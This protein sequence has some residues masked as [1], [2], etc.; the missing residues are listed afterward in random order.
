MTD[1][2]APFIAMAQRIERNASSDFAGAVVIVP[3]SD[4]N[5]AAG[6]TIE[7]LFLDRAPN[8]AIFWSTLKTAI[9]IVL[10]ELQEKERQRAQ[11]WGIR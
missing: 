1:P 7:T 6:R 11:G 3:P 10:G 8:P 9:D 4:P 5:D 2:G